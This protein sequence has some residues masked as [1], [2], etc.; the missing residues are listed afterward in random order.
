MDNGFSRKALIAELVIV[1]VTALVFSRTAFSLRSINFIDSALPLIVAVIF[2]YM[3][4]LALWIRRRRIDFL[5]DSLRRYLKSFLIFLVAAIIVFPVFGVGAHFWQ[6]WVFKYRGFAAAGFPELLNAIL[7][8]VFL[9]ALPEEFFFRGYFQSALDSLMKKRWN[10]FGAKLG[11]AWL[12]TALVFAAAH[13][14]VFYQWWHFAIF[15]PALLFGYLRE[16]TGS[17]TAPVLF[18]A[19]S[20][21]FMNWFAR[22]YYA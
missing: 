21:L 20:N 8:Q 4:I 2:L 5:D 11:W 10:V 9:V 14:I 17:I 13:T 16:R 6:L 1:T 22:S 18:H 19:S 7:F 12:I 15:F 3:P